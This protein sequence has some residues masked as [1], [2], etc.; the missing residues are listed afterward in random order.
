MRDKND[1]D[2]YDDERQ[3]VTCL[4]TATARDDNTMISW[5]DTR[6]RLQE[7][8]LLFVTCLSNTH[9]KTTLPYKVVIVVSLSTFAAHKLHG[10]FSTSSDV[11]GFWVDSLFFRRGWL[12]LC[13]G[14]VGL[15]LWCLLHCD[16]CWSSFKINMHNLSFCLCLSWIFRRDGVCLY[17]KCAGF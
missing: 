10:N 8:Y 12:A 3:Y 11:L 16:C 15:I 1:D 2:D 4:T 5:Q 7:H 13:V 6:V 9:K 14:D 17:E